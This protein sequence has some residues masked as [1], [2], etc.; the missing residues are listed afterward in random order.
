MEFFSNLSVTAGALLGALAGVVVVGIFFFVKIFFGKQIRVIHV[1]RDPDDMIGLRDEVY[2]I[3]RTHL[4]DFLD[5]N[6][7]GPKNIDD[8][9]WDIDLSVIKPPLDDETT[10]HLCLF[11]TK[12]Y[13]GL[14]FHRE[15]NLKIL[16]LPEIL[17]NTDYSHI[18]RY[19]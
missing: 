13:P 17:E 9:F 14:R 4:R 15:S 16:V 3:Y 12:K 7:V 19:T 2:V 6:L 1:S 10:I 11:L 8:V 18:A 5:A